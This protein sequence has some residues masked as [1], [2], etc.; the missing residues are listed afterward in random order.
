MPWG[1]LITVALVALVHGMRRRAVAPSAPSRTHSCGCSGWCRTS[2]RSSCS[3]IWPRRRSSP[4]CSTTST[5][6]SG[7]SGSHSRS[8]STVALVVIVV[9]ARADPRRGCVGDARRGSAST[10]PAR[11]SRCCTSSSRRSSSPAATSKRTADVPYGEGRSRVLDVYLPRRR[12]VTGPVL[13]YFHGGG[14]RGGAKNRRPGRWSIGSPARA[15]CASARATRLR[16]ASFAESLADA[17]ARGRLGS[18]PCRRA[19]DRPGA[20]LRRRQLGRRPPR[21]VR[22]A[23]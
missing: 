19:R 22:R 18:N 14:Y 13:V 7:S 12:G 5:P 20:G 11:R 1:Y 3:P 17:R 8:C 15:G 4:R 6:R 10:F 2:C 21:V 23:H 16:P 9:R